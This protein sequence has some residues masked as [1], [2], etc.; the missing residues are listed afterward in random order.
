[1]KLCFP[2]KKEYFVQFCSTIGLLLFSLNLLSLSTVSTSTD[3]LCEKDV[4]SF[5]YSIRNPAKI[6]M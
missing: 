6:A 3:V 1:M 4:I 2:I 5:L